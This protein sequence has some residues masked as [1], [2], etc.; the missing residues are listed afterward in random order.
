[1]EMRLVDSNQVS[2]VCAQGEVGMFE[3]DQE[4]ECVLKLPHSMRVPSGMGSVKRC[5]K[6]GC[7]L[8]TW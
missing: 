3:G 1:M 6:S 5:L 2:R 4:G 7:L 8:M